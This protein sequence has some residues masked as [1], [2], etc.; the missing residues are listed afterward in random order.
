MNNYVIRSDEIRDI[1]NG[2]I[3]LGNM[4][5]RLEDA[6]SPFVISD[7]RKAKAEIEKGFK[8]VRDQR[9]AAWDARN[10]LFTNIRNTNNFKSVWSIYEVGDLFEKAFELEEGSVLVH[11]DYIIPLPVGSVTWFRMWVAADQA[12]YAVGGD[13]IYIESL[14]RSSINSKMILL[15]TGS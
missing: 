6:L 11:D 13:H 3:R 7:L 10:E 8:S 4:I 2:L 5:D 14:T 15:G 9:D 12:I 1:H